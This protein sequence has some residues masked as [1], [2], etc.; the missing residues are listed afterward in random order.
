MVD[1][2]KIVGGAGKVADGAKTFTD[3]SVWF[4]KLLSSATTWISELS[5]WEIV[6]I[7][8][9]IFLLILYFYIKNIANTMIIR[10]R[11]VRVK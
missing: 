7:I 4:S 6:I 10:R 3:V 8:L 9:F 1:T 2:D 11:F 5:W